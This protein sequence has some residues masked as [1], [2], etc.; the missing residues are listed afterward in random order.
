[1]VQPVTVGLDIAKNVFHAYGV[2]AQGEKVLSRKL[3]RAQVEAIFADFEP[4]LVGIEGLRNGASLGP[5]DREAR[6]SG[7]AHAASVREA[8]RE[9]PK[10]R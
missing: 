7:P 1:M 10:E 5:H 2:D 8:L 4:C 3:R 6:A 9:D